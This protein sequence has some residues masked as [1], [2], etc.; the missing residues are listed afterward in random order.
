MI[1]RGLKHL[2]GVA[3][4]SARPTRS[5]RS[6]V[7][8]GSRL[9]RFFENA[10]PQEG[11]ESQIGVT[12]SYAHVSNQ[13]IEE[14]LER[15]NV[16]FKSRANGQFVIREC[17]FCPKPHKNVMSNLWT[18]NLK[19]NSGAFLCFRCGNHGSWYDF[20]RFILG[21]TINFEKS[22]PLGESR[23]PELEI[24][25]KTERT[26]K[27]VE[28]CEAYYQQ[29]LRVVDQLNLIDN[30]PESE[31]TDPTLITHL[32]ILQYLI[33]TEKTEQRHLS[34]ET[35]KSFKIGIGEEIFKNEEGQPMRIPVV[36]YPLFR[37]TVKK[38]KAEK[39]LNMI[40]TLE[41]DC[42]RAKLRGVGKEN[43]HYQ[44]FKPVG[45]HPGVFGLNTFTAESKVIS[46]KEG[47]RNN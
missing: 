28:E 16:K 26:A 46:C 3:K 44:R 1:G 12:K 15:H 47:D 39:D 4:R 23:D 10:A 17:P 27:V 25:L 19:E 9:R 36:C 32:S 8:V 13:K 34:L 31:L 24:R 29:L 41:Y 37:P 20:V 40:D 18:L 7:V 14:F 45:G 38:G 6:A 30:N 11:F 21:D 22:S 33:G 43:K 42:V 2:A 5:L 35:L